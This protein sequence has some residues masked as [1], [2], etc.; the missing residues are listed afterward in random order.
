MGK[1]ARAPRRGARPQA[2][3]QAKVV[4]CDVDGTITHKDRRIDSAAVDALREAEA[5]G[6]PVVLATGNVLP[7]AYSLAY[8]IGTSGPIVAENGGLV[9]WKGLV[10]RRAAGRGVERVAQDVER[11]LGLK[12]LFTDQWRVTEVAYPEGPST[13]AQVVRAARDHPERGTVRIERTGFAVHIMDAEATKF[14][15]VVRALELIGRTPAEAIALGD[16]DND[17]GMIEGCAVGV[18]LGDGSSRLKAAASFVAQKPAGAGIRQALEAYGVLSASG[19]AA[20]GRR[21]RPRR[22]SPGPRPRST[23]GRRGSPV[24]P[25]RQERKVAQPAHRQRTRP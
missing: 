25:A 23:P 16:S 14:R 3:W 15:G 10:E 24:P 9:F 8:L 12:R 20:G 13:F 4:V 2:A 7:I 21:G 18:A 6:V 5:R 17:V 11:S 22:A 19:G 1:R